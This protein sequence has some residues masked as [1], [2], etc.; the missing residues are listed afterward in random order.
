M[1]AQPNEILEEWR[2]V[3][4]DSVGKNGQILIDLVPDMK[5]I[6]GEQPPLETLP[7]L[8]SENRFNYVLYEFIKALPRPNNPLILLF[9][10]FQW[11]D[12]GSIKLFR[13]LLTNSTISHLLFIIIYRDNEISA[14]HPLHLLLK[15]LSN[16][17]LTITP[18]KITPLQENAVKEILNEVFYPLSNDDLKYLSQLVEEKT[19]GNPFFAIQFLKYLYDKEFI[20]FDPETMNWKVDI[21]SA[22]NLAISDNVIDF[23]LEKIKNIDPEFLEFMKKCSLFGNRFHQYHIQ[24][25]LQ[26]NPLIISDMLKNALEEEFMTQV[27]ATN[28]NENGLIYQFSHDRI[29]Q[30]FY[31]LIDIADR[32][33][34][35]YDLGKALLNFYERFTSR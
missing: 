35:H 17:G 22:A 21:D 13:Y 14:M 25:F 16:A 20:E 30:V 19:H 4:L 24:E 6:I 11:A 18:L 8:E 31:G 3:I 28:V 12:E 29:Q 34:L 27:F 15:D 10:D 2:N 26:M 1:L 33:Q 32:G 23:L 5:L 7:P 9:D